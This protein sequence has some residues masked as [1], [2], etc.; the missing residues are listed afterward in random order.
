MGSLI[1]R[2]FLKIS[3]DEKRESNVEG[4]PLRVADESDSALMYAC[5]LVGIIYVRYLSVKQK[6]L[7]IWRHTNS[8]LN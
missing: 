1:L 5:L 8:S 4:G 2:A 7:D 3:D 6:V